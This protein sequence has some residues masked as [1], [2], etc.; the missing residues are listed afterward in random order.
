MGTVFEDV[1]ERMG[2]SS[3][4]ELYEKRWG[5]VVKFCKGVSTFLMVLRATWNESAFKAQMAAS[6]GDEEGKKIVC[7]DVTS[8]VNDNLFMVYLEFVL[9]ID[10]VTLQL[11]TWAES[12]SCHE[13]RAS[14]RRPRG[15]KR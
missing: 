2:N 4:G 9:M 10:E 12:C 13:D 7:S 3:F 14:R 8:I 11:S 5:E 15:R 1:I 6:R